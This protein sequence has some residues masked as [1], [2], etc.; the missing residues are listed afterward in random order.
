MWLAIAAA[1]H[2]TAEEFQSTH[3]R[4]VWLPN[5]VIKK[6]NRSFNP[7]THEGCDIKFKKQI[8][9]LLSFNPHTHEGCDYA[10]I[11]I[12]IL[13]YVSIHTPT[14]GVTQYPLRNRQATKVSIHTPT[15][16]VTA[17]SSVFTPNLA[18]FNPHTHEGCDPWT[19]AACA[20]VCCFNPHT[21]EGC[22]C[23]DVLG[24]L[25][26][27]VSIHTPTKGVTC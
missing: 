19:V 10:F 21:H 9:L 22:D 20:N 15:K 18:S 13:Y 2:I 4:R 14:K 23:K 7:H 24:Q 11:L 6:Y 27:I 25:H 12:S 8:C 5:R 3:P 16:G 26:D 1:I 17:S